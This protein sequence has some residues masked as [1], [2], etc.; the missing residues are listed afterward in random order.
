MK[1]FIAIILSLLLMMPSGVM[2]QGL[3]GHL[4]VP[5]S[6]VG[7]SQPYHPVV[8]NGVTL[9]PDNP[10]LF[11][12]TLS[13]GDSGLTGGLLKEEASRLIRYFMAGLTVP[14]VD[15]WVNL[16]PYESERI[17]PVAFGQTEMGRDLLAQDY[18]LKQLSASLTDPGEALGA[19]FWEQ[20]YQKVQERLGITDVPVSTFNK[21]WIVPDEARVYQ[22]HNTA[23]VSAC[24]LKVMLAEDLQARLAGQQDISED[25]QQ[26]LAPHQDVTQK[27]SA[28]VMRR[29]I[30]PVIEHE[31]NNGKLFAPLR[32][33]FYSM[34]LAAWYKKTLRHS[35]ITQVYA[36]QNKVSGIDY[37]DESIRDHIY[38]QYLQAFEQGVYDTIQE[39]ENPITHQIIP[40]KYFSGG[41]TVSSPMGDFNQIVQVSSSDN[42]K[43]AA[44]RLH[45]GASS[46]I[47]VVFGDE[48][49]QSQGLDID[50]IL[51]FRK[52][53]QEKN[54]QVLKKIFK[55]YRQDLRANNIP[56]E[57]SEGVKED[58]RKHLLMVGEVNAVKHL[59]AVR[60]VPSV[61]EGA[62]RS[63][64]TAFFEADN[65]FNIY[66]VEDQNFEEISYDQHKRIRVKLIK[67][68]V[69][70]SAIYDEGL[71]VEAARVKGEDAQYFLD[72]RSHIDGHHGEV[73]ESYQIFQALIDNQEDSNTLHKKHIAKRN[74][75]E[76]VIQYLEGLSSQVKVNIRNAPEHMAKYT[77]GSV[78]RAR[79]VTWA[80][81]ANQVVEMLGMMRGMAW[82]SK[83]DDHAWAEKVGM[84][85]RKFLDIS[86][87]IF[88]KTYTQLVV[89]FI[90]D[91]PR[92]IKK[93][94]Q[95]GKVIIGVLSDQTVDMDASE[96]MFAK[97][98]A[99]NI[100]K[101]DKV[102]YVP[103]LRNKGSPKHVQY[104]FEAIGGIENFYQQIPRYHN[105]GPNGPKFIQIGD[106][107]QF[108]L[109]GQAPA[110]QITLAEGQYYFSVVDGNKMEDDWELQHI[111]GGEEHHKLES[112]I[113]DNLSYISMIK[114]NI[115]ATAL[116]EAKLLLGL[117]LPLPGKGK[118]QVTRDDINSAL[119]G[120]EPTRQQF[121]VETFLDK[122][123]KNIWVLKEG[124]MKNLVILFDEGQIV[125]EEKTMVLR[126]WRQAHEDLPMAILALMGYIT[127]GDD[128]K[129]ADPN[130]MKVS[131]Q[132]PMLMD[133]LEQITNGDEIG[134]LYW[135]FQKIQWQEVLEQPEKAVDEERKNFPHK[136]IGGKITLRKSFSIADV[137]APKSIFDDEGNVIN[138]EWINRI[139]NHQ[140]KYLK[141][142]RQA[143][144]VTQIS[145][146]A[147]KPG[148]PAEMTYVLFTFNEK[149][150]KDDEAQLLKIS[151]MN[152]Y[153]N[154]LIVMV[155]G[156]LDEYNKS[157]PAH[158]PI[159][160]RR[161][162]QF[163]REEFWKSALVIKP[164]VLGERG[165]LTVSRVSPERKVINP[166]VIEMLKGSFYALAQQGISS[167]VFS[168]DNLGRVWPSVKEDIRQTLHKGYVFTIYKKETKTWRT[169][170]VRSF[171]R[172]EDENIKAFISVDYEGLPHRFKLLKIDEIAYDFDGKQ[173]MLP[174][175]LFAEDGDFQ[176][177]EALDNKEVITDEQIRIMYNEI[178]QIPVDQWDG[179]KRHDMGPLI[180]NRQ[181]KASLRYQFAL[182]EDRQK[183]EERFLEAVNYVFDLAHDYKALDK[184]G[185]LFLNGL[186]NLNGKESW[187]SKEDVLRFLDETLGDDELPRRVTALLE[188]IDKLNNQSTL[189]EVVTLFSQFLKLRP[190]AHAYSATAHFLFDYMLLKVGMPRFPY[191]HDF[192][193]NL[194]FMTDQEIEMRVRK[195][196]AARQKVR[197]SGSSTL[198]ATKAK[199]SSSTVVLPGGIL[200]DTRQMTWAEE[201]E[202]FHEVMMSHTVV[203]YPLWDL[204][205]FNGF[206]M[207]ILNMIDLK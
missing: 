31:V 35:L 133:I 71:S 159:L 177:L 201:R 114:Q 130:K 26:S 22:R 37:S 124:Y 162:A 179:A 77:S 27:I 207:R 113:V 139:E 188:K 163:V 168:I 156:W 184:A 64:E 65:G 137:V 140:R 105:E 47:Q 19:A 87:E 5:G 24:R 97:A 44:A 76:G 61:Q 85:S 100:L 120:L 190:F 15:L 82:H 110:G 180:V 8:L 2:A 152:V 60:L 95:E 83:A 28:E 203:D 189:K 199:T 78:Q 158:Q 34:I 30:L 178:F 143:F 150:L 118:I 109:Q 23:M 160:L 106:D 39:I 70:A 11:D 138:L 55:T 17:M 18:V 128:T 191:D 155:R 102:L 167:E 197:N 204:N 129:S 40:R 107:N 63:L 86:E 181:L 123:E 192:L 186:L 41:V 4:P 134:Y 1:K 151:V 149:Y 45:H 161:A 202:D 50:L 98:I 174:R 3:V 74:M 6:K 62:L 165:L 72:V 68:V 172:D 122:K 54:Q 103:I 20:V 175:M 94:Q 193:V 121:I 154:A 52:E 25:L 116:I 33:V 43:I 108:Y 92:L 115:G 104:L 117:G 9:H 89:D 91:I 75:Y 169:H 185:L 141:E 58:V 57:L 148:A 51:T 59:D 21:V 164:M 111:I 93:A 90:K 10:F 101:G 56:Q 32:Q 171:E 29:D 145:V 142:T 157:H 153:R 147:N 146:K 206:R 195:A 187:R 127:A 200:M 67:A 136:E 79:A 38:Q 49:G 131:P 183:M 84:F 166:Q 69:Q 135:L 196:F 48:G 80:D 126:L 88:H 99:G 46:S 182:L 198:L 125:E 173:I 42:D 7:L 66:V 16:S 36:D 132:N 144:A 73:A 81:T 170:W 112:N 13:T 53:G 119:E 12:F 96:S 194:E 205:A 176:G 14:E